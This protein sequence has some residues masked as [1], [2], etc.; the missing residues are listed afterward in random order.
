MI[1]AHNRNF[2]DALE[3]KQWM[4]AQRWGVQTDEKLRRALAHAEND[5]RKNAVQKKPA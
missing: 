1:F 3:M 5:R 4:R 2:R